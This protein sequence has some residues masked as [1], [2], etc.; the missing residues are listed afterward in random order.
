M[1]YIFHHLVALAWFD[2]WTTVFRSSGLHR[3]RRGREGDLYPVFL[4]GERVG[5]NEI[6]TGMDS[7]WLRLV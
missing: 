2:L 4:Q 6:R 7:S 1:K 5:V 3:R